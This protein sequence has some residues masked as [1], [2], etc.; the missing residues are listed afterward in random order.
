MKRNLTKLNR[1]ARKCD[2]S[3]F[4]SIEVRA[5]DIAL[6]GD[7]NRDVIKFLTNNRFEMRIE[8]S[9]GWLVFRRSNLIITLT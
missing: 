1:L 7:F 8:N 2:M 6:Q 5:G 9:E 3:C 4:Y